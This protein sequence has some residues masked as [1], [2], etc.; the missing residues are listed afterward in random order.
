MKVRNRIRCPFCGM[1][2]WDSR[3]N[4]DYPVEIL[5][6]TCVGRRDGVKGCFKYIRVDS[7]AVLDRM[8]YFIVSPPSF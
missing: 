5:A 6:M 7:S 3:W 2:G 8:K 4:R 1:L